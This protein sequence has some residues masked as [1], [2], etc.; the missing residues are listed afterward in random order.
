MILC[1]VML[2]HHLKVFCL[3]EETLLYTFQELNWCLSKL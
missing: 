3:A 1:P 2:M